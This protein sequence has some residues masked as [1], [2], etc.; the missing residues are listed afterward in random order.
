M[1]RETVLMKCG[2]QRCGG[3]CWRESM[4][5]DRM[6]IE[7]GVAEVRAWCCSLMVHAVYCLLFRDG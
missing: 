5:R 7:E 3:V 2:D 1:G 6:G 4:A